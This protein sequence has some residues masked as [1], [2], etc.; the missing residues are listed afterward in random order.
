[1]LASFEAGYFVGY[2]GSGLLGKPRISAHASPEMR[3][4]RRTQMR[5][6][7]GAPKIIEH[8]CIAESD[9]RHAYATFAAMAAVLMKSLSLCWTLCASLAFFAWMRTI[10][11]P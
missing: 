2:Y 6:L 8:L 3:H 9:N 11:S 1:M 7:G 4:L 5:D 10:S